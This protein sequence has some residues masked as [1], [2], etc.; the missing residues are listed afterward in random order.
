MKTNFIGWKAVFHFSFKQSVSSKSFRIITLL[1]CVAALL[2]VPLMSMLNGSDNA[3]TGVTV[4]SIVDDSGLG[5]DYSGIK[6][7]ERYNELDIKMI[8][9]AE[10]EQY[11]IQM[12]EKETS[13]EVLVA[14]TQKEFIYSLD[15]YNSPN[16]TLQ[17]D[18]IQTL[19]NDINELFMNEKKNKL[20]LS[21]EQKS[22]VE[23]EMIT[24]TGSIDSDGEYHKTSNKKSVNTGNAL[25]FMSSIMLIMI[26]IMSSSNMVS[27]SI[28]VEKANNVINLIMVNVKAEAVILGK[29]IAAIAQSA[30]QIGAAA[31]CFVGS[32]IL[33]LLVSEDGKSVSE[34]FSDVT[35]GFF[36]KNSLNISG[37][38]LSFIIILMGVTLFSLIAAY[39]GS[40]VSKLEEMQEG[41]KLYQFALLIG[42]YFSLAVCFLNFSGSSL[43][44]DSI[45]MMMPLS[46]PFVCPYEI[47]SGSTSL[48]MPLLS[49]ALLI[50][51]NVLM[52][53]R[54]SGTYET[55]IFSSAEKKSTGLFGIKRRGELH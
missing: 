45:G 25:F 24:E 46:A 40:S 22:I 17:D 2:F 15:I 9:V 20:K 42:A 7:I 11:I 3:E 14:I 36:E 4:L 53:V 21:D 1:F 49:L 32:L 31:I 34:L 28:V 43:L 38:M 30:V 41:M 51:V 13:S 50:V 35:G 29:V 19:A 16:T 37:L 27:S 33:G 47:L 48:L 12:K 5:I 55:R 10:K 39:V 18:D 6:N 8:P 52:F 26:F 44:L 54:V 23:H